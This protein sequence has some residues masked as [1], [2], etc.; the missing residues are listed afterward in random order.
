MVSTLTSSV[1]DR[2]FEHG[3]IKPKTKIGMCCFS[4]KH[5]VLRVK[6][7]NGIG[8]M[9]WSGATCSPVNLFQ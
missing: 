3:G 6:V 7:K 9:C 4:A 5:A 8:I 2:A 1:V